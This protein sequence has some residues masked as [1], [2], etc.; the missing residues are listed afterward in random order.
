MKRLKE[1]SR[2]VIINIVYNFLGFNVKKQVGKFFAV[3]KFE[4]IV[5]WM[6]PTKSV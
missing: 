6:N 3:S 1:Q 2:R 4:I 5:H